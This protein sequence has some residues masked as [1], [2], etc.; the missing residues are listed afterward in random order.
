MIVSDQ[1]LGSRCHSRGMSE[2]MTGA[3]ISELIRRA[4]GHDGK[5]RCE[6]I[7]QDRKMPR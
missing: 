4:N 1:S 2:S 6:W 3:V 5:S 7:N